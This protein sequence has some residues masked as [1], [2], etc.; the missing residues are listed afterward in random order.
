M[1]SFISSLTRFA[2]C[3]L[4]FHEIF[5]KKI[6]LIYYFYF[7][8][9]FLWEKFCEIPHRLTKSSLDSPTS[10]TNL[11]NKLSKASKCFLFGLGK[12]NKVVSNS[13]F[14]ANMLCLVSL[15][16]LMHISMVSQWYSHR[17]Q[18]YWALGNLV[19]LWK[20]TINQNIF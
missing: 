8:I 20:K 17:W 19:D 7:I 14:L 11:A 2:T 10:L 6:K 9:I 4:Q 12:W 15:I 16:W 5:V 18:K 13:C 1:W 3:S